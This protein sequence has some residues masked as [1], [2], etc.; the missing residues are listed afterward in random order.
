MILFSGHSGTPVD[1]ESV[2]ANADYKYLFNQS[3]GTNLPDTGASE[4]NGTLT[5]DFAD[6]DSNWVS[7]L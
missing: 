3:E 2:I 1:P 6:P 5:N 4:N 7:R